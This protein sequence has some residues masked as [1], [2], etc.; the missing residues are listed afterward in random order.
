TKAAATKGLAESS[1]EGCP[2]PV[3]QR[4]PVRVTF[5]TKADP[6]LT[7][8]VKSRSVDVASEDESEGE[9]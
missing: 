4:N 7:F 1:C 2:A 9:E 6:K 5:A 8:A 3:W